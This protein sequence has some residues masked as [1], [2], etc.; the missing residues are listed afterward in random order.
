MNT[1]NATDIYDSKLFII[2]DL[3]NNINELFDIPDEL[4]EYLENY[5]KNI[6]KQV[7][8]KK[9]ISSNKEIKKKQTLYNLFVK[10]NISSFSHLPGRQRLKEIANYWKTSEKG[11]FFK[12]KSIIYKKKYPDITIEELYEK[13][14]KEYIN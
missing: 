9:I 3:I 5:K 6:S 1:Y 11:L 12:E 4:K 10:H 14:D 7:P 2:N 13:I 8:D